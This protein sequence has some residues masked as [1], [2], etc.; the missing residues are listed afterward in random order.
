MLYLTGEPLSIY[1]RVLQVG[2]GQVQPVP[3]GQLVGEAHARGH[4]LPAPQ[5]GDSDGSGVEVVNAAHQ[6]ARM[7]TAAAWTFCSQPDGGLH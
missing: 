4:L 6:E 1:G 5:P 3:I 7:T 2:V